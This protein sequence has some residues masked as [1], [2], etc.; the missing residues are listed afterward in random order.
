MTSKLKNFA[1]LH[2]VIRVETT[3]PDE[4]AFRGVL[5]EANV[6]FATIHEIEEL[7][8][9]GYIALPNKS[10]KEVRSGEYEK[11]AGDI[12]RTVLNYKVTAVKEVFLGLS[13]IEEMLAT[14]KANAIWPAVEILYK[15]EASV[16][17][18]PIISLDAS[19]FRMFCYDAA[20]KWESEYE[21][22]YDEIFKI[23]I[24]SRY[25]RH[26]NEYMRRRIPAALKK[27]LS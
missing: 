2:S 11:C 8:P 14:L 7:E 16:Y 1:R 5:L 15:G 20:G 4:T 3:H 22:D 25:V 21:L 27:K 18:G 26:F 13:T 6:A 19:S 23:E 17:I 10:V 9:N 24:E 12:L